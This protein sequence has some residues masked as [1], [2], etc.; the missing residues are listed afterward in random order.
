M[1]SP[2][3]PAPH[4]GAS[5]TTLTAVAARRRR[6]GDLR[7][8]S[9]PVRVI[10]GARDRYLNPRVARSFAA[11]FPDCELHLLDSAGHYVQVDEPQQV[12]DLIAG[13]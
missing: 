12:A 11:L 4:S 8:F 10:F 6:L 9:R 2:C 3:P 13:E 7:R 1:S 5:T